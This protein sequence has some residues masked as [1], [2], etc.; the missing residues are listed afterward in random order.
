[1][2]QKTA[3][4]WLVDQLKTMDTKSF[5]RLIQ[6]EMSRENF[7]ECFE[8]AK[9]MEKEQRKKDLESGFHVGRIYQ[10][11]EA[12]TTLEQLKERTFKSE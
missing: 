5:N 4:E 6:I 8:Q 10:G 2:A 9:A 7:E 3:V 11:R 12:D 1:M